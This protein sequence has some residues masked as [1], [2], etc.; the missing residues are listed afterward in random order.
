[1]LE[2]HAIFSKRISHHAVAEQLAASS[3][4]YPE[5][6]ARTR[7]I[8]SGE[9][10]TE[11]DRVGYIHHPFCRKLCT[12]CSFF[13]VLK[14]EDA[15]SRFLHV[16]CENLKRCGD[17]PYMR[18][19]PFDAFYF[20]GG[21]PTAMRPEQMSR[22]LDA[23][24][25]SLSFSGDAEFSSESTFA[26][27]NA[28]MLA[29]LKAGGVNRMSLG[30]QTFSPRLRT[31]IGRQCTP[32]EV[33]KKIALVRSFMDVVNL[34]LVYNFP[35]QTIEEWQKDLLTAM[36]TG[37]ETVSIHPLVP[38]KDSPLA[39]MIQK[40]A[41][42]AMG[43]ERKQYEFY[44]QVLEILPAGGYRQLNFCFFSR[45]P[46]ERLRYFRHRF[47]EGDCISFGPGAVGNYGALIYF[48]MPHVEYYNQMVEADEFP[49]VAAGLFDSEFSVA[50]GI[51]EEILF[52]REVNKKRLSERYGVDINAKYRRVLEQLAVSN[53]I[54]D[55]DEYFTI[56]PLGLFWAHNMGELF[57]SHRQ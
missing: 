57:Q 37:V 18:S 27:I 39:D 36:T 48:T 17:L 12:F 13:R 28:D 51:S 11:G 22:L 40:G 41:V 9:R 21:T 23:I 14:D 1:M 6:Q 4:P 55:R 52:G 45:S 30:V 10:P 5:I 49:A 31:F 7:E 26:A 46:K 19:H 32:D 24:R 50:W 38:V 3:L 16:L 33:L 35:T 29:A 2:P 42:E 44:R 34:D 8:I 15:H 54:E 25:S 56:T 43:D 53:L 20:G 47:Q